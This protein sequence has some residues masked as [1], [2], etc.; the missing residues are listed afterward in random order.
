MTLA[1]NVGAG[2]CTLAART[3]HGGKCSTAG[4]ARRQVIVFFRR[5]QIGPGPDVAPLRTIVGA[6]VQPDEPEPRGDGGVPRVV[7][8]RRSRGPTGRGRAGAASR[9][10]SPG[11]ASWRRAPA[12]VPA[13]EA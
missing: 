5:R 4:L 7:A 12:V 6:G 10:P 8:F 2:G 9:G 13:F 11:R 1:S 3:R